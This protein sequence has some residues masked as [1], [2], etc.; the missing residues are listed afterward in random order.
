MKRGLAAVLLVA[1]VSE[2]GG[3]KGGDQ[4]QWINDM[5]F[6]PS[7]VGLLEGQVRSVKLKIQST[8]T[9][10]ITV[11]LSAAD[12]SIATF[13]A[14]VVFEPGEFVRDVE[15]EGIAVGTTVVTA[16]YSGNPLDAVEASL[17]VYV[18]E[19]GWSCEG[20]ASGTIGRGGRLQV[21]SDGAF[22]E[23]AD[24]GRFTDV[25][26]SI[27]CADD[28]VADGYVALGPAIAF[29]PA[30]TRFFR[31]ASFGVPVNGAMMP[32]SARTGDVVLF[33]EG[34]GVDARIVPVANGWIHGNPT[35][36]LYQFLSPR[37]GTYQA[38]VHE[39]AGTR[40]FSRRYTYRG[41]TGV[42]MG[43]G[44]A[45]LVGLRNHELFDFIAPLGGPANWTAMMHY[46]STYH[47][48]GFCTALDTDAGDVGEHCDP[49]PLDEMFEFS[50][51]F[52]YWF[53]PDGRDGQG[54]T[55]N[56]EDYCQIFRDITRAFGNTG[57][58]STSS[59]YLPPGVSWEWMQLAA[60]EKC[61]PGGEVVLENFYDRL[62]N[63]DGTLPVITFCDGPEGV[64]SD[65]NRD[66]GLWDP[67][68]D[69]YY[70]LDIALAVDV[71]ANGRRDAH[72]PVLSQASEPYDDFG[73]DGLPDPSE[74]G[75]DAVTNPD[76]AGDDWDYQFNPSGTEKNHLWDD[77]EPWLDYGL[78]G[79]EST[80]QQPGGY[81]YGEDNG[82]FDYNPN[83][84]NLWNHDA[85]HLIG[86]LGDDDLARI[87]IF[88]DAG[89]RDLFDFAPGENGIMGALL[90]R[91]QPVGLFRN[92]AA[93]YGSTDEDH[94]DST[95]VDYAALPKNYIILY[96]DEDADEDLLA[97]GDGGHVG[98]ASQVLNRLATVTMAMSTRWPGGDREN[99][100]QDIS[101]EYMVTFDF[102]SNGRESQ[103]SVFLPPGYHDPE[104]LDVYYPVVYFLHGY[105]QEPNDLILSAI[106]FGNNMI[107][108]QILKDDRMQ[109]VIMVFPDGRCRFDDSAEDYEKECMKG[110]F[111][112]DSRW[113]GPDDGP[114]ME[115]ILLDLMDYIDAT[116]RTKPE[117]TI[118]YTY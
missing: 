103:T 1:L 79:V 72:E 25:D 29:A 44:G 15:M 30:A 105:G 28:I 52:E 87:D 39:Q 20:T 53:Y 60:S 91:G 46:I 50:Q 33:Y 112:A 98:T 54:G 108:D 104:N 84:V 88:T 117:E 69:P 109:K 63:P 106:V 31:E 13:P 55:F 42:S 68:A 40:T 37:F 23:F 41:V 59:P 81:D 96:G 24:D 45:G 36:G 118:T 34:A 76:P 99:A 7:V 6:A 113:T 62:Y 86:A 4:P 22:V 19:T 16:V 12:G 9:E 14:E 83:L 92:F 18:G 61:A 27:A 58:Y 48:G 74:T 8:P 17:E 95:I 110:S 47:L 80:P 75:Y 77:G 57:L 21:G 85:Q 107:S 2:C 35:D 66:V 49:P 114:Q 26:A 116:Y 90:A 64:D 5:F 56:R 10:P 71:N 51:E 3:K 111:Y 73:L 89:I 70:P 78:D 93:L 101:G 102:S 97:R 32:V 82:T 43:G 115:S 65:G 100:M 67:E 38:A 11:A 94:F